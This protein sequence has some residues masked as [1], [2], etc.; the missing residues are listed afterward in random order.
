MWFDKLIADLSHDFLCPIILYIDRTHVDKGGR[1]TLEPLVFTSSIFN[2]K[3]RRSYNAW[4]PLG[5]I[6]KDY[7][8]TILH[9]G[10]GNTQEARK[11]EHTRIKNENYHQQLFMLLSGL[12]NVQHKLDKH[13]QNVT[14]TI[15]NQTELIVRSPCPFCDLTV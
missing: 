11:K 10:D 3:T 4:H 2:I 14:I 13:L 12:Q 5:C 8:A 7:E 9:D 1:Y 15:N 6:S